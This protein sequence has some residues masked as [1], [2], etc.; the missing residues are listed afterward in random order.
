MGRL[1]IV[2]IFLGGFFMKNKSK[3]IL[4]II[5]FI[6]LNLMILTL[7]YNNSNPTLAMQHYQEVNFSTG[8][9]TASALNVRQGPGT[10]FKIIDKVY[11]NTYIRVF[12]KIGNWYVVQLDNDTIGAV[13][14]DYVRPIYPSTGN[15]GASEDNSGQENQN[16]TEEEKKVLYLINQERTKNG[17]SAL[18]ID[19]DVQ[20]VA[21][22][23]ALD[24]VKNNYFSH[25]SPTYG[26]PFEMLKH[27]GVSYKTAGENIAGNS[28]AESAV[29]AWM[30]SEGHRKNILNSSYDYT[31]IGIANSPKYGKIYVQMFIKK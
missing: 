17:L 19:D 29:T 8:F 2:T 16:L 30:N 3:R 25:N 20:N 22:T 4:G 7:F 18:K 14:S 9:V 11:K 28:K 15:G 6:F 13:S 5:L 26:T 23:K 27:F 31:G 12:A 21:R 1:K 24:M 10:N